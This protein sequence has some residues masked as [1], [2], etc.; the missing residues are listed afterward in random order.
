[1]KHPVLYAKSVIANKTF[2][3]LIYPMKPIEECKEMSS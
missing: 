2:I 3:I 1:M